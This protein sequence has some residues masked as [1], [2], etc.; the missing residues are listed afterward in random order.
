MAS[1]RKRNR[2]TRRGVQTTWVADY[3][4][5]GGVRRQKTFDSRKAADAWMVAARGEVQHGIHTPSS[6]SLTIA[7][8]GELWIAQGE[9]DGLER[10][11]LAQYRQHLD[12][13]LKPLIGAV[14]LAALSPGAVQ[15][16]RN[17]LIQGGRSRVMAK[18][19]V[20]SLGAVLANAM[21]AGKVARNWCV[22][23]RGKLADR[24]GSISGT[25]SGS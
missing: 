6:T 20:G 4:D 12:Y 13:H 1:I 24:T 19:V 8:A 17:D 15:A 14:K 16:L 25:R 7:E 2:K 11:T 18:K 5:Q 10:S 3:F 9:N 22:S 23:R 21:S